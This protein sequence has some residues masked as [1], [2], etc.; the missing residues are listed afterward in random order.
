VKWSILHTNKTKQM[1]NSVQIVVSS[2]SNL[3]NASITLESFDCQA[4]ID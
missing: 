3:F 1:T 2:T 4:I